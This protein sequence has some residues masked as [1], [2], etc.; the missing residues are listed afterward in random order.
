MLRC[1]LCDKK[2]KTERG[3]SVHLS[4]THDIQGS[5]GRLSLIA[6]QEFFPLL[7]RR[8]WAKAEKF[9]ELTMKK[10]D[11]DEWING[12]VHAL[13]G[14]IAALKMSNSP[15]QPYVVKLEDFDNKKL[16]EVK[17]MFTELSNTL[18]S[19]NAFDAAYFQAWEDFTQYSL[20][21]QD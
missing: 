12:Y 15:P 5:H 16:H 9:L 1:L 17:D 20:R 11:E 8:R 14:M 2:F 19:K 4:R 3:L 6:I 13:S 18:D 21:T 10:I 7:K